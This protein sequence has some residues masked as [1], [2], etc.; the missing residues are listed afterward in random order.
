MAGIRGGS[1]NELFA[2]E[3]IADSDRPSLVG[4]GAGPGPSSTHH[5]LVLRTRTA[6]VPLT[7][8]WAA[9]FR[10][11]RAVRRGR[12][13]PLRCRKPASCDSRQGPVGATQMR[14][15][16]SEELRTPKTPVPSGRRGSRG[17]AE[18]SVRGLEGVQHGGRQATAFGDLQA[19]GPSPLADGRGLLAVGGRAGSG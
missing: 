19:G 13:G 3:A 16:D 15:V 6:T 17:E 10:Q 4:P 5:R 12:T 11:R 14:P 9:T 1:V 2:A 18:T 7:L 8:P